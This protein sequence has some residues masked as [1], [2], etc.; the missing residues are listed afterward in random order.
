MPELTRLQLGCCNSNGCRACASCRC[1]S[2]L[3]RHS[4]PCLIDKL[5]HASSR[6]QAEYF[7]P[8]T[9]AITRRAV[10][11]ISVRT[12]TSS[13][14]ACQGIALQNQPKS[15]TQINGAACVHLTVLLC[16][17]CCRFLDSAVSL[18]PV[19]PNSA[20]PMTGQF[21]VHAASWQTRHA[22]PHTTRCIP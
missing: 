19:L 20:R 15:H 14:P 4:T 3:N 17:A 5:A 9:K 22:V 11:S 1:N 21:F 16:K 13:I 2:A 8:T 18:H 10:D 12:T 7:L 6:A